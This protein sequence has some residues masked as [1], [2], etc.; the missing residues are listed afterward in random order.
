MADTD[1]VKGEAES[2]EE[3]APQRTFKEF[4]AEAQARKDAEIRRVIDTAPTAAPT[5]A[6][7][8]E[9]PAPTPAPTYSPE[10]YEKIFQ[11]LPEQFRAEYAQRVVNWRD[12]Q[13][14]ES[15]GPEVVEVLKEVKSDPKLSKIFKSLTA[16]EKREWLADTAL[17]IYDDP[18]YA[19]PAAS[20]GGAERVD[21]KLAALEN[22]VNSLKKARDDDATR[23]RIAAYQAERAQEYQAFI[24]DAKF[25]GLRYDPAKVRFDANGQV[26]AAPGVDNK[27]RDVKNAKRIFAIIARAEEQ[28]VKAQRKVSYADVGIEMMDMWDAQAANPAPTPIPNT[29]T[30]TQPSKPQ[31]PRSKVEVRQ[32]MAEQVS[33]F[34]TLS[35]LQRALKS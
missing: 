20:D 12:Q 25:S 27:D 34:G 10:Q 33:K 2:A 7:K 24:A 18:R 22:E 1:T 28:S 11:E 13:L 26:V 9:E 16:K 15:W 23:A 32:R 29:T 4:Q 14:A 21:P 17:E 19:A 35:N 5:P 30:Q 31:A 8:T 6:P 3:A